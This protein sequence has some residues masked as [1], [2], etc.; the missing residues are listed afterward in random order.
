MGRSR[1]VAS[2]VGRRHILKAI[3][4]RGNKDINLENVPE[5]DV[6]SGEVKISVDFCGICATDIEEYL[7]GPV[8]IDAY[9]PNK[10]TGK[11]MPMITGHEI[12]G[13]ICELGAGISGL[14]V[15]QR[16]VLNGVLYCEKCEPCREGNTTQCEGMAAVGFARDGGLAEYLTW[17][18][19]KV[20][21]L[22]DNVSSKQAAFAEPASV[23]AHAVAKAKISAGQNVAI[24]GVG[25]VGILALQI[26]YAAGAKVYAVDVNPMNLETVK[27]VCPNAVIVDGRNNHSVETIRSLTGDIGPDVVIDA[28]GTQD[29]PISSIEMV[30]RGGLVVLVAIYVSKS[31]LNFNSLVSTEKAV[32][33]SLAY[34]Q[35]DV[36]QVVS[37]MS[38]GK[39]KVDPLISGVISLDEV[40]PIGFERMMSPSKDIFRILVNPKA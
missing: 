36:E 4:Y 14:S 8:F 27:E 31:E 3:V 9:E 10:V 28:A 13:T 25:T 5:P 15:G 33:G 17:P 12:T 26:A 38:E 16:V 11:M 34:T 30:R 22:S 29:T 18:A 6:V 37:L 24:L 21:I 2:I 32:I 23:A 20:V 19:D 40:K 35:K 1:I 39:L 7:Y